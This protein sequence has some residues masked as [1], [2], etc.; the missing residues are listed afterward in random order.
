[1]AA[2]RPACQLLFILVCLALPHEEFEAPPVLGP[3]PPPLPPPHTAVI[4]SW[5][6]LGS[7]SI[8]RMLS[9]L[10][11]LEFGLPQPWNIQMC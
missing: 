7:R 9:L 4:R 10:G 2:G 11:G 5:W 1:M 6:L 8:A 3:P